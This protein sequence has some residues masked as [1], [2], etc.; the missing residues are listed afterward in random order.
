MKIIC[1]DGFTMS[2]IDEYEVPGAHADTTSVEIGFPSE[3]EELLDPYAEGD[4]DQPSVYNYVPLD[5]KDKVIEKHGGIDKIEKRIVIMTSKFQRTMVA[6]C[7]EK[8]GLRPFSEMDT[9]LLFAIAVDI[10]NKPEIYEEYGLDKPDVEVTEENMYAVL[11]TEIML[12]AMNL[13]FWVVKRKN[14]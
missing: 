9:K 10:I 13:V 8:I 14:P 5:I 4:K 12:G 2:V 11:P 7:K 6:R 3:R 1:K